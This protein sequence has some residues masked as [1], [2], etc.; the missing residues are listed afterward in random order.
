MPKSR[1]SIDQ[2]LTLS[3]RFLENKFFLSFIINS[4]IVISH[5]KAALESQDRMASRVSR[6]STAKTRQLQ[7]Q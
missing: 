3:V 6:F 1:F 2:D 7:I 4:S 5:V